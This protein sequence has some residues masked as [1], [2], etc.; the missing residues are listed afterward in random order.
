MLWCVFL[1][2]NALRSPFPPSIPLE[3][4]ELLE[5]QPQPEELGS[6]THRLGCNSNSAAIQKKKRKP[7]VSGSWRLIKWEIRRICFPGQTICSPPHKLKGSFYSRT[8]ISSSW[9]LQIWSHCNTPVFDVIWK[10][11]KL[12]GKKL[13]DHFSNSSTGYNP[14]RR[15]SR[16]IKDQT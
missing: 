4:H 15:Q 1:I 10:E 3:E 6:Q 9:A 11:I 5:Q 14:G 7:A 12:Y 16:N 8:F 13:S 2:D